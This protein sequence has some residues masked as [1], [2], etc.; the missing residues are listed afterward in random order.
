MWRIDGGGVAADTEVDPRVVLAC[1][2]VCTTLDSTAGAT[3]WIAGRAIASPVVGELLH[4]TKSDCKYFTSSRVGLAS[5]DITMQMV[6]VF[7][8]Y[9][10]LLCYHGTISILSKA[11]LK[12]I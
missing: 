7:T 2:S 10:N 3:L 1:C 9:R 8:K 5:K 12:N 4:L 6:S 11:I